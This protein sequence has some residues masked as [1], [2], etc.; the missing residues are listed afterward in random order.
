MAEQNFDER[1]RTTENKVASIETKID[2]FIGEMRQQNEMR[3][4]EIRELD[5]KTEARIAR[6][7]SKFDEM[8]K[9]VRNLTITAMVG[10]ATLT[11]AGIAVA[12]SIVLGGR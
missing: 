2:M 1:L 5:S 7:E 4:S 6:I 12:V 8:G 9:H 3:A 11:V 10:M